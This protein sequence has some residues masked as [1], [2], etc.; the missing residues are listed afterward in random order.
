MPAEASDQIVGTC[1][2]PPAIP[3]W[4]NET[5]LTGMRTVRSIC[6]PVARCQTSMKHPGFL[7]LSRIQ[8]CHVQNPRSGARFGKLSHG[9]ERL[10]PRKVFQ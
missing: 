9:F 4:A 2:R 3:D 6:S 8:K 10:V 5:E 7:L 1:R